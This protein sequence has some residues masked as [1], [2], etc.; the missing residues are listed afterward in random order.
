MPSAGRWQKTFLLC[1]LPADGKAR[2]R[3]REGASPVRGLTAL[4]AV[5]WQMAKTFASLPSAG[6]RQ[7]AAVDVRRRLGQRRHFIVCWQTASSLPSTSRRQSDQ[8]GQPSA[9]QVAQVAAT[10]PLCRLLADGKPLC[11]LLADGKEPILPHLILFFDISIHFHSKSKTDIY[12]TNRAYPTHIT[13]SNEH[14]SNT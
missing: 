7:R 14:I 10:W 12:I 9:S 4:F 3:H 2:G 11:H 5:C 1:C 8:I 13:N 6:R